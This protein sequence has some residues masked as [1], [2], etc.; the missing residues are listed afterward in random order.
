MILVMVCELGAGR[1]G[2]G[3]C[4]DRAEAAQKQ[5]FA[6]GYAV[7]RLEV[8]V[9]SKA[10]HHFRVH[11][12]DRPAVLGEF[13]YVLREFFSRF[14]NLRR[15]FVEVRRRSPGLASLWRRGVGVYV[16]LELCESYLDELFGRVHTV[17]GLEA[18]VVEFT[19]DDLPEEAD[20]KS[21]AIGF[22]E[23]YLCESLLWR[24]VVG[25]HGHFSVV[26]AWLMGIYVLYE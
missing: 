25:V 1:F 21:S 15:D 18:F 23:D 17:V 16:V 3:P 22:F 13:S 8:L 6:S 2:F 20:E 24:Y 11:L 10:V 26:R 9:V 12:D 4:G 14:Q 5:F 19:F 7:V